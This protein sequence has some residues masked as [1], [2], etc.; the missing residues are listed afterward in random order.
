MLVGGSDGRNQ[1]MKSDGV[2]GT[3]EGRRGEKGEGKATSGSVCK[4]TTGILK[5]GASKNSLPSSRPHA[6]ANNYSLPT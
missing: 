6:Y 5:D 4:G 1:N 3:G 2:G